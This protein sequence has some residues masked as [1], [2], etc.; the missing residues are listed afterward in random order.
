[1]GLCGFVGAVVEMMIPIG[2]DMRLREDEYE[3]KCM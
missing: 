2:Y 1:M 3:C